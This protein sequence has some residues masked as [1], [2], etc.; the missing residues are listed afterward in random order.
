M[1]NLTPADIIAD[2][3]SVL[4]TSE[5]AGKL[6]GYQT[7]NAFMEEIR[8]GK[9]ALPS[10]RRGHKHMFTVTGIVD[11]INAADREFAEKRKAPANSGEVRELADVTAPNA[12]EQN[13]EV[14]TED[15]LFLR[16]LAHRK[17]EGRVY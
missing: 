2:T 14:A 8:R 15:R 13:D 11:L 9:I 7:T 12:I 4:L 6:L 16:R 1:A 3:G 10:I 5:Q 17:S